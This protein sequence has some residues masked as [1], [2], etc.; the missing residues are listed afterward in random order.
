MLYPTE[1]AEF[2]Q[3]LMD[4]LDQNYS[5]LEPELRKTLVKG[6]I[7]MRNKN[8]LSPTRYAD[9]LISSY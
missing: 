9:L 5:V 4:L 7:L 8:F 6:L 2:P 1:T 3:L